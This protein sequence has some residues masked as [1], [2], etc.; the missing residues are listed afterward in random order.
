MPLEPA[1]LLMA[2]EIP[3]QCGCC[4]PEGGSPAQSGVYYVRDNPEIIV[5]VDAD[6]I[7][8]TTGSGW[9][10]WTEVTAGLASDLVLTRVLAAVAP[11]TVYADGRVEVGI[12]AAGSEV[13]IA[14]ST[15]LRS[16]LATSG[17]GGSAL[18]PE[19]VVPYLIAAGTRIALRARERSG[20][21]ATVRVYLQGYLGGGPTVQSLARLQ[22]DYMNGTLTVAS[23]TI[24]ET[25]GIVLNS[26]VAW[27][28]T[29]WAQALASAPTD[30]LV[31][32]FGSGQPGA[33]FYS[34]GGGLIQLG[35]GAAG[36][37]VAVG[38][39]GYCY[40]TKPML[41]GHPVLVEA[42]ERV[43]VRQKQA[44]VFDFPGIVI[45]ADGFG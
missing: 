35:V 18:N 38:A 22:Q 43:A 2:G 17:A 39:A 33:T 42:G 44:A 26:Y 32:G 31:Y 37:E 20:G 4:R 40:G 45:L 14:E 13:A 27:A 28:W 34:G 3:T 9:T 41:F 25:A 15:W 11:S 30:L 1:P 12:G 36:S 8:L 7:T 21:A 24:P 29:A 23:L 10:A 19:R 16:L 6:P 5:P